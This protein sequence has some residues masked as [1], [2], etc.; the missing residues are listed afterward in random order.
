MDSGLHAERH[1]QQSS[2]FAVIIIIIINNNNA[3]PEAGLTASISV[4][5]ISIVDTNYNK[6]F[7]N[8]IIIVTSGTTCRLC[9]YSTDPSHTKTHIISIS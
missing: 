1:R 5:H 9:N 8:A 3:Y 4:Q 7:A 6:N 2:Q